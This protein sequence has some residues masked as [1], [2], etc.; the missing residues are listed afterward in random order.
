MQ[1]LDGSFDA[2]FFVSYHGS[3]SSAG[4]ALSHTYVPAAFSEVTLNGSV[5]GEEGI[6]APVACHYRIPVV[7]V[8]GDETTAAE[9]RALCPGIHAAVV[10]RSITRFAADSVHPLDAREL[11][12]DAAHAA[13]AGAAGATPPEIDLPATLG[14]GFHTSD[15]AELA[16]RIVGVERTGATSA[17]ISSADPLELFHTFIT[18]V[19]L[20]RGFV[21]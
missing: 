15:Y 12:R 14:L 11:I 2:V 21:E 6:N 16:S 5:V 18:V 19:L 10:K 20:C 8:T 3:M 9:L 17:T 7:L 4:S 1:G 13:V